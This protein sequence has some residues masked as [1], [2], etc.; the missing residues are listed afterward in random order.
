LKV[1]RL[2]FNRISLGIS[3][4]EGQRSQSLT[5]GMI[6]PSIKALKEILNSGIENVSSD[7]IYGF[8]GDES[9]GV[10]LRPLIFHS[11]MKLKHLSAYH[12]TFGNRHRIG[13]A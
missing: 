12:L 5:A 4:V 6:Q 11:H 2:N 8:P 10:G 3:V 9:A 7:L 1:K 13:N